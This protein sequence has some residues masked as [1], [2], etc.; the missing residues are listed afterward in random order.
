MARRKQP[1][2]L[3]A[4]IIAAAAAAVAYKVYDIWLAQ[5]TEPTDSSERKYTNKSIA[6]TLLHSVLNL[7]LPL[8]DI[9]VNLENVTFILPPHLLVDDLAGNIKSSGDEQYSVPQ[10][11]IKNYKLLRCSNI[12]GYFHLVKN[13]RPDKL[14]VCS[15]DLG[16]ALVVPKDLGRFVKEIVTLSQS[17]EDVHAVLTQVFL[18]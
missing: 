17:K 5:H 9:L 2:A 13:L 16:I 15:D 6:L 11:L 8:N 12:Q 14:Y 1:Q 3:A 10:T 18:K 4:A 7:D